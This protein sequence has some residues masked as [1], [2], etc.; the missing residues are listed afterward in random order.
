M[1]EPVVERES[2]AL[3]RGGMAAEPKGR[4]TVRG[5][6]GWQG[7]GGGFY[8]GGREFWETRGGNARR[9][10]RATGRATGRVAEMG[11]VASCAGLQHRAPPPP[12]PPE[13]G[14]RRRSFAAM[15][16]FLGAGANR[17]TGRWE[18]LSV[19]L[20]NP[21]GPHGRDHDRWVE[22]GRPPTELNGPSRVQ[23][24]LLWYARLRNG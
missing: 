4:R 9:G 20:A 5:E 19:R 6:G 8:I 11:F 3:V 16:F 22:S 13:G 17:R 12:P 18:Y 24:I 2:R 15:F 10:A 1:D 14:Q 7:G 23:S 21:A